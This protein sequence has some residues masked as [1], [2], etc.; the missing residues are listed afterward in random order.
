MYKKNGFRSQTFERW[1]TYA[2][3]GPHWMVYEKY[4][5]VFK[6]LFVFATNVQIF[7]IEYVSVPVL[8]CIR[9]ILCKQMLSCNIQNSI[10]TVSSEQGCW[11]QHSFTSTE[12]IYRVKCTFCKLLSLMMCNVHIWRCYLISNWV[13]IVC[14]IKLMN[15]HFYIQYTKQYISHMVE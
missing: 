6:V 12:S 4:E 3:N 14:S 10:L 2:L 11:Y 13:A 1:C 8:I 15:V 5:H 9:P 7:R